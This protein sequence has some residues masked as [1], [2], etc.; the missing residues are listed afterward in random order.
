MKKLN[1]ILLMI[2]LFIVQ[3]ANAQWTN[4]GSHIRNTNSGGVGIGITTPTCLLDVAKNATDP[5]LAIRN[6]GGA[7]GASF[8]LQ[9]QNSGSDWKIKSMSFGGLKFR[10]MTHGLNVFIIENNSATNSIY[11]KEGGNI[12]IGNDNP[13]SILDIAK[14]ATDPTLAIRNL[15]GA[16]G[17][18][19]R[20]YDQNSNSD[21]K[22][23]SMSSGGLKFRDMTHSL[24]VFTIEN[25]SA[26]NSIYVKAGGN[27]GI[28][29][30]NPQSLL[31][32]AKASTEPTLAIRNLGGA[33]G[34]TINLYDESSSSDWKI[35]SMGLGGMKVRDNTFGLNVFT[36]ENNS[37]ENAIYVKAG[38]NVGIGTSN[39]Q[40]KLAVNGKID[41]KEVEVY[42][43]GWSDYVF[44]DDYKLRSLNEVEEF[45]NE[46]NHLPGIPSEAEVLE[47]G[48][49]L[50]EMNA[51]LL[52]KIEELTLYLIELKKENELIKDQIE[53]LKK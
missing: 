14:N 31:D 50:G 15:G 12:G 51:L 13:E 26:A 24:N 30:D 37:S 42:L 2:G 6:L 35:K 27:V 7:A 16:A 45:I 46:N 43:A 3:I 23:K 32:I 25:N 33:G 48:I 11:I 29:T 52:E 17:A 5:T 53:V 39:P 41:C 40:T 20:L 9:D 22:I 10:D 4:N 1:F 38:G 47:N 19:F 44:A 34:A 8:R 49:S 36:I 21:W 28:G 18:S